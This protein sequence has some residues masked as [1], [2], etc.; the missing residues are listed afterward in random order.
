MR[1]TKEKEIDATVHDENNMM[2][3][4]AF[5][6]DD[7][8]KSLDGLIV[9]ITNQTQDDNSIIAESEHPEQIE[10]GNDV[11]DLIKESFPAIYD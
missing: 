8:K 6:K 4:P 7:L 1:L 10:S 11:I 9:C 3:T 5:K 2:K